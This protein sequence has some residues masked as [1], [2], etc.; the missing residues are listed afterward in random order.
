MPPFAASRHLVSR[1]RLCATFSRNCLPM[2]DR[3]KLRHFRS[4]KIVTEMGKIPCR[5]GALSETAACFKVQTTDGIPAEFG[6][7]ATDGTI[8]PCKMVW[9]DATKIGVQFQ[10]VQSD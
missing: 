8:Y 4:G 7:L 9:R 1:V 10:Y 3:R 6:F 2:G 5:V